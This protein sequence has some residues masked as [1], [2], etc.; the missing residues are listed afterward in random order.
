[1]DVNRNGRFRGVDVGGERSAYPIKSEHDIYKK[2]KRNK[3]E[4]NP[5]ISHQK[6]RSNLSYSLGRICDFGFF[7]FSFM[8]GIVL[9]GKGA[10]WLGRGFRDVGILVFLKLSPESTPETNI[11]ASLNAIYNKTTYFSSIS[12]SKIF[13]KTTYFN[14]SFIKNIHQNNIFLYK[15]TTYFSTSVSNIYNRT[16]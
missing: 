9:F 10:A 12:M 4:N 15:T 5:P 14:M 7:I 1:M 3:K 13:N 8:C 16:S 2:V 11:V 6:N